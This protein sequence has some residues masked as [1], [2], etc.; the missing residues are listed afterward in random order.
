M[1]LQYIGIAIPLEITASSAVITFW[2]TDVSPSIHR[3]VNR[4][5]ASRINQP[6]HTT[7]YIMAIIATLLLINLFGV[8][9]VSDPLGDATLT[10]HYLLDGLE[11]VS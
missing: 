1:L 2:D 6:D 8:R 10:S 3:S 7:I 5:R 4:R 9:S 11:T